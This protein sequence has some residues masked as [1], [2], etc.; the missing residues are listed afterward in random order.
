MGL[1]YLKKRDYD[2]YKK[3]F[4]E[5]KRDFKEV[6]TSN[7]RYI[8]L[9]KSKYYL[10][11]NPRRD[12]A[13]K[14]Q[15]H[16]LGVIRNVKDEVIKNYMNNRYCYRD[17]ISVKAY[18]GSNFDLFED[19]S[20]DDIYEID[21]TAAYPSAAKKLGLLSEKTYNKFFEIETSKTHILRKHDIKKRYGDSSYFSGNDCLKYSKKCRLISLGTLAAK[22]EIDIYKD[23]EFLETTLEYDKE[24]ANL[25]YVCSFEISKTM[26]NISTSI[27][28]VYFYWV[29]AIFCKESARDEVI[30]RLIDDGYKVKVKK[31]T[32]FSY[33]SRLRRAY[34]CKNDVNDKHPYFFSYDNDVYRVEQIINIDKDVENMLD[35]YKKYLNSPEYA[36]KKIID[37]AK[38]VYGDDCTIEKIIFT[39]LCSFLGIDSPDDLNLRYLVKAIQSRGLSYSEFVHIRKIVTSVIYSMDM[40]KIFGEDGN[41]ADLISINV[42]VRCFEN[43]DV[44][45]ENNIEEKVYVDEKLGE[46]RKR[47]FSYSRLDR[48]DDEFVDDF[49][50]DIFKGIYTL[51]EKSINYE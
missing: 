19:Y 22:K 1:T 41:I 21:I 33:N 17:C 24:I 3:M 4:I 38:S 13:S 28:G 9:G 11:D 20:T 47:I 48:I 6:R 30:S 15:N 32:N 12:M 25:F 23:G 35:W 7:R 36:R 42:I 5:S 10:S 39:D 18:I 49:D 2:Y 29:D 26:L 51:V 44:K 40:D 43:L 14:L 50:V 31:L 46:V 45:Y 34:V 27:D 37:K 16:E 8:V